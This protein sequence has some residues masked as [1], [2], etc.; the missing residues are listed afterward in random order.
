MNNVLQT[1]IEQ[2]YIDFSVKEMDEFIRIFNEIE[3]LFP[4]LYPSR[5]KFIK[6]N[7]LSYM[8][9]QFMNLD[10]SKLFSNNISKPTAEKYN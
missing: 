10:A 1:K 3:L 9:L 6:L 5:K 4:K 7:Y 8:I 2:N